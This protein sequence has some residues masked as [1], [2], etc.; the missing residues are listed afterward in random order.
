[1]VAYEA[2]ISLFDALSGT[3]EGKDNF[4][5]ERFFCAHA[6]MLSFEGLPAIYVHSL[7]G[8]K[9]DYDLLLKTKINRAINRH[10]YQ[11]QYIKDNLLDNQSH[12]YK[13]FSTII[14][15]IEIR[16][17]N[18]AFHPNAT[19]YTLNLGNAFFAIWR[20]SIDRKQSIFAIHNVTNKTQKLN[21]NKLNIKNLEKWKDIITSTK[22]DGKR[23]SIFFDPYQ[24]IWL[25]N[26]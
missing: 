15:L 16:K 14:T 23:K 5:Y 11:Y 9:N 12:M 24:F 19:Q 8:T 1:M 17:K 6:M 10:T 25:S 26:K 20:Q 21:I 22:H 13:I 7:F 4:S 2:N 18:N 3:I